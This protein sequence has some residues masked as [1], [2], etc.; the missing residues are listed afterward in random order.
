[1]PYT[2]D[3]NF[4]RSS[5]VN[6]FPV[7]VP[8]ERRNIDSK[9]KILKNDRQGLIDMPKPATRERVHAFYASLMD[10]MFLFVGVDSNKYPEC[11]EVCIDVCKDTDMYKATS[12]Y[13][14]EGLR[15]FMRIMGKTDALTRRSNLLHC[16]AAPDLMVVIA[17]EQVVLYGKMGPR[18]KISDFLRDFDCY[19][20]A[21]SVIYYFQKGNRQ[22]TLTLDQ[23]WDLVPRLQHPPTRL[24][25]QSGFSTSSA[26]SNDRV[27][28]PRNSVT[29]DATEVH[30]ESPLIQLESPAER[31]ATPHPIQQAGV[32]G[33][34]HPG[35]LVTSPVVP[36]DVHQVESDTLHQAA[37]H[38]LLQAGQPA[39]N[40]YISPSEHQDTPAHAH[41]AAEFRKRGREGSMSMSTRRRKS[42]TM[43][44]TQMQVSRAE[45]MERLQPLFDRLNHED[46]TGKVED[47]FM[48]VLTD[49]SIKVVTAEAKGM[50]RLWAS[51]IRNEVVLSWLEQAQED[52]T[53]FQW[54][55]RTTEYSS[56]MWCSNQSVHAIIY[57]LDEMIAAVSEPTLRDQ[58]WAKVS[59]LRHIVASNS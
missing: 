55:E 4:K 47:D 33:T 49:K 39:M 13:S 15:C 27:Q 40:R 24:I 22:E 42:A 31:R 3:G 12:W 53:I 56:A 20:K 8:S 59:A 36:Y 25:D 34:P 6:P 9:I 16:P 5:A 45:M 57:D 23:P 11:F 17:L 44:E 37:S 51:R 26:D 58:L 2:W 32:H 46:W 29:R 18:S 19:D 28:V 38:A 14:W 52:L 7:V 41:Q 54:V 48:H 10:A 35:P 43:R 30:D 50:L 21:A 1:M